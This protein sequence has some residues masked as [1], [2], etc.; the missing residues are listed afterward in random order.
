MAT[1]KQQVVTIARNYLR[2][3]PKFFQ[4]SFAPAGRTYDLGA[5]NIDTTGA[6]VAYVPNSASAGS[7]SASVGVVTLTSGVDYVIDSRNSILRLGFPL[8]D[9]YRLLVEGYHFSWINPDDM[10]FYAE[11]AINEDTHSLGVDAG[12]LAPAVIDTIG[13]HALVEALYGLLSEFSRDIDVIT[14]ESVHIQ[15]SQR[16]RM[17]ESLLVHWQEE[18]NRRAAALNIGLNRIE[19]YTL[20]RVSRATNRL[21]PIYQSREYGDIGPIVRVWP[22]ISTGTVQVENP[23]DNLRLNVYVEGDPPPAYGYSGGFGPW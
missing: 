14:S 15:A 7:P 10:S 9:G 20:R 2:D 8:L 12:N 1:L 17:V 16:Y 22:E 6:W 18:Y 4:T 5:T 13:I 23:P 19:V 3:F 21:V 11:M